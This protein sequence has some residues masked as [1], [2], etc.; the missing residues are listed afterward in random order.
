MVSQQ[1]TLAKLQAIKPPQDYL[2]KGA[3]L[4]DSSQMLAIFGKKYIGDDQGVRID[5]NVVQSLLQDIRA[6]E[7]AERV[8]SKAQK[9]NVFRKERSHRS[10][11]YSIPQLLAVL[12]AGLRLETESIQFD[13]VAMHVRCLRALEA[14]SKKSDKFVRPWRESEHYKQMNGQLIGLVG[15]IIMRAVNDGGYVVLPC[16]PGYTTKRVARDLLSSP[17]AGAHK[18]LAAFLASDEHDPSRSS[19]TC[20]STQ[21]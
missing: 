19:A 15:H 6:H 5:V 12:E 18:A 17:L 8:A 9:R 2:R 1:A 7:E 10:A 21:R 3:Q 13:Y 11:K 20:D 16:E 14:V 4:Q